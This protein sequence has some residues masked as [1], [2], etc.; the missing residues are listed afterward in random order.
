MMILQGKNL[1]NFWEKWLLRRGGHVHE[2]V[3]H[4]GLSVVSIKKMRR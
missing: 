4:G 2:V 3:A 1:Y